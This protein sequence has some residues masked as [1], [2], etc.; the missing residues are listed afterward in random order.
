[1]CA[2]SYTL[3]MIITTRTQCKLAN[4]IWL[5]K[6]SALLVHNNNKLLCNR[7]INH[8]IRMHVGT[9]PIALTMQDIWD[10]WPFVYT[11]KYKTIYVM[12]LLVIWLGRLCLWHRCHSHNHTMNVNLHVCV[13]ALHKAQRWTWP[14]VADAHASQRINTNFTC[15]IDLR[16]NKEPNES[17]FSGSGMAWTA[18]S[19]AGT[20]YPRCVF[21]CALYVRIYVCLCAWVERN[22]RAK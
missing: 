8:K 17:Q 21:K 15:R 2:L 7:T 13:D 20:T 11:T 14:F 5:K 9:I 18:S 4:C 22:R 19:S 16:H 12:L 3:H 1:M 10:Q 6:N